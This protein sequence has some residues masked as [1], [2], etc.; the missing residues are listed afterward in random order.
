MRKKYIC[1]ECGR[2]FESPQALGGHMLEHRADS[3]PVEELS[4][5]E[6]AAPS[7]EPSEAEQIREYLEKGLT[8]EQLTKELGFKPSTVRQ[9]IA[10]RIAPA[11]PGGK[12]KFELAALKDKEVI[13]PEAIVNSLELPADGDSVTVWLKGLVNGIQLM[14]LGARY[15]QLLAGAQA[16]VT[17]SQLNILRE[18]RSG[19]AEIAEK[20]AEE[21]AG[22]VASYFERTQPWKQAQ[23]PPS[24]A[25][26]FERMMGPVADMIGQQMAGLIGRV[27]G[28]AGG[29]QGQGQSSPPLPQGWTY[30]EEGK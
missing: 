19:A 21:A 18:S 27:L 3:E 15:S 10:K 9:E 16:E 25:T 5:A 4:P 24:A 12:G 11:Q 17:A 29:T 28:A 13:P 8:F 14:L 20:A 26:P 30:E 22:K 23:A 6:R 1:R 7:E 2:Q